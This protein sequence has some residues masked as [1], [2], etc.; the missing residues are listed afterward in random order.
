MEEEG[1]ED[2]RWPGT[3]KREMPVAPLWDSGDTPN[4]RNLFLEAWDMEISLVT[5]WH[6]QQPEEVF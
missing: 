3:G 5:D 4:Q 2:W 1:D 6:T